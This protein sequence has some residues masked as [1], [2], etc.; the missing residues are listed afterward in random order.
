[1]WPAGLRPGAVRFAHASGHFDETIAFYRDVLGVPVVGEFS[2]S[3]GED[4]VIFGLPDTAVQLEIVRAR[5]PEDAPGSFDQLVF[6][7]DDADAVR[8]AVA[9]LEA[10]GS[11]PVRESHPYWAARGAVVHRD[12]DGRDVV[13]APWVF[14]RDPEPG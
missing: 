11:E 1:M 6:Y 2:G 8:A 3:F 13:F 14:G 12:P 10:A 7:L 5:D 9:P 4:G